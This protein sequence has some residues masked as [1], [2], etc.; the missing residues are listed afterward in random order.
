MSGYAAVF[1]GCATVAAPAAAEL[2]FCG[3]LGPPCA[4]RP[5]EAEANPEPSLG[6]Q[7]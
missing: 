1:L 6:D 7:A 3:N 2:R 5:G 4:A